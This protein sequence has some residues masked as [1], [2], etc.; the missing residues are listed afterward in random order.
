MARATFIA[1]VC[2]QISPRQTMMLSK[3]SCLLLMTHEYNNAA[4]PLLGVLSMHLNFESLKLLLFVSIHPPAL[5]RNVCGVP[6]LQNPSLSAL[7]FVLWKQLLLESLSISLFLQEI[8][9][10]H[11]VNGGFRQPAFTF[12]LSVVQRAVLR[13]R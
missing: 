5:C 12:L 11:K 1:I 7:T 10:L 3:A 2:L 6:R 9:T 13:H 4:S 8:N